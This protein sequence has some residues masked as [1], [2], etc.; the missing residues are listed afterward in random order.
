M[1]GD[2]H[3]H[4]IPQLHLRR[5]VDKNGKV[6]TYR[7]GMKPLNRLP[8]ETSVQNHFYSSQYVGCAGYGLGMDSYL[9]ATEHKA[10]IPYKKLVDSCN[11]DTLNDQERADFSMFLATL[12]FRTK[13]MRHA[14]SE[15]HARAV[16]DQAR[17][18]GPSALPPIPE[19]LRE[20]MQMKAKAE[21]VEE[22]SLDLF[23]LLTVEIPK[24]HSL[25]AMK[26]ANP[27]AEAIYQMDW[28]I[29]HVTEGF[30]VTGDHPVIEVV[31]VGPSDKTGHFSFPLNPKLLFIASYNKL[32]RDI[33][34]RRK[35]L[36][37][38][39]Q[40]RIEMSHEEF[41]SH[42][43]HKHLIQLS[44]AINR[45]R[46]TRAPKTSFRIPRRWDWWKEQK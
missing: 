22:H 14:V 13:G 12:V 31:P 6:W 5:F 37:I 36:D 7:K 32:S 24:E 4:I 43:E 26:G 20:Y 45:V 3:Q 11:T 23:N 39:N 9:Q 29:G 42:S 17:T 15:A 34:I 19:K 33:K 44:N 30:L 46:E 40:I 2:D 41:Y 21:G 35:L 28:T 10:G 1:A 27:M 8:K 16:L 18:I 38:E 25:I